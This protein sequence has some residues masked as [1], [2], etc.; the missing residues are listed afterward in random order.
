[1]QSPQLASAASSNTKSSSAD[2]QPLCSQHITS[3]VR[4]AETKT[5][6]PAP[7]SSQHATHCSSSSI[8]LLSQTCDTRTNSCSPKPCWCPRKL[9]SPS[10]INLPPPPPRPLCRTPSLHTKR[11]G[12]RHGQRAGAA[13]QHDKSEQV[14]HL[15]HKSAD[16]MVFRVL[17]K[18]ASTETNVSATKMVTIEKLFR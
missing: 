17:D 1:M 2:L 13:D 4:H 5:C 7:A 15:E 16:L 10:G 9:T 8:I 18:A 3:P 6:T 12:E 14:E 11:S